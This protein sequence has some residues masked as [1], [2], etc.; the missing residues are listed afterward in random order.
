MGAGIRSGVNGRKVVMFI[1]KKSLG[2]WRINRF[3]ICDA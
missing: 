2:G 3:V 1:R